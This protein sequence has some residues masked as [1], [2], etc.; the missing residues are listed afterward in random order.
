MDKWEKL[1]AIL[2]GIWGAISSLFFISA[3]FTSAFAELEGPIFTIEEKFIL[4]P[5][6]V[7]S[8]I[9]DHLLI[10]L[11]K[12]LLSIDLIHPKYLVILILLFLPMILSILIGSLICISFVKLIKK[13]L[14]DRTI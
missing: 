9:T 5:A 8:I 11:F 2:G 12:L 3:S 4:F 7:T 13:K 1:G 14:E 6:Y 10:P